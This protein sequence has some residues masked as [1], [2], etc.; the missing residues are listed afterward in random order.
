MSNHAGAREGF[1]QQ[2]GPCFNRCCRDVIAHVSGEE[3]A[4]SMHNDWRLT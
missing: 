4:M 2:G 1:P 3:S